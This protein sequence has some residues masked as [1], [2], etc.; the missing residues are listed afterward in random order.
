LSPGA[1]SDASQPR[2]VRRVEM[3]ARILVLNGPYFATVAEDGRYHIP[4]APAGTY[5]VR[6]WQKRWL[7]FS[8]TVELPA[9]GTRTVDIAVGK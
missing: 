3:Q 1:A 9:S 8:E 5:T 4:D 7:P 2:A 6:I